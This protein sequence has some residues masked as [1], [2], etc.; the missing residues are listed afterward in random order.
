MRTIS[1]V[2]LRNNLEDIVKR[3]IKGE[4]M[5]LTYRGETVARLLPTT[6]V[7]KSAAEAALE[8]LASS[9]ANDPD[10]TKKAEQYAQEVYEDRRSY[11]SREVPE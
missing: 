2:D 6:K 10:Y 8:R 3:L 9:H 5:E 4:P 1:A 11:G 7:G